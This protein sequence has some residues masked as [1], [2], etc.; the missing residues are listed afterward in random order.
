VKFKKNDI[1]FN[2][3]DLQRVFLVYAFNLPEVKQ[4]MKCKNYYSLLF[5][6][7]KNKDIFYCLDLDKREVE[8]NFIKIGEL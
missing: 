1:L 3:K 8:N 6:E 4:I 5:Y 7:E 2:K